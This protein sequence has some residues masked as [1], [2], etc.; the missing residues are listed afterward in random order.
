MSR[1]FYSTQDQLRDLRSVHAKLVMQGSAEAATI[2]GQIATL[3]TAATNAEIAAR[4]A[5]LQKQ[6]KPDLIRIYPSR[7][8]M[9][10]LRSE[11]K[12]VIISDILEAEFG[13]KALTAFNAR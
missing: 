3:K 1:L 9:R 10:H 2:A 4:L 6:S 12:D 11:P 13:R 7:L 5:Q 8:D